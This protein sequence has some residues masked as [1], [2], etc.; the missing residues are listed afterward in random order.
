MDSQISL[1]IKATNN[2]A[3]VFGIQCCFDSGFLRTIITS[4]SSGS[5]KGDRIV[6]IGSNTAERFQYFGYWEA[7]L[8]SQ[9]KD[10]NLSVRN[11]DSMVTKF[12]FDHVHW[13]LGRRMII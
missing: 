4:G 1:R 5:E 12:V 3:N 2:E 10:L 11:Q 8:Q 6:F 9:F 13:I 7:L